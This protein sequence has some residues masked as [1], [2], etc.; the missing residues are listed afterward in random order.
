MRVV[1]GALPCSNCLQR[2]IEHGFCTSCTPICTHRC[3]M[4]IRETQAPLPCLLVFSPTKCIG[5]S[6]SEKVAKYQISTS[7]LSESGS[8]QKERPSQVHALWFDVHFLNVTRKAQNVRWVN[9]AL[10]CSNLFQCRALR[11]WLPMYKLLPTVGSLGNN[12]VT[13]S[14]GVFPPN[15]LHSK[16]VEGRN[17]N[18]LAPPPFFH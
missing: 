4:G 18:K 9:G 14:V 2:C 17:L 12:P 1:K 7:L 3:P 6:P 8:S 16:C 15:S 10:L 13:F 5:T 11:G